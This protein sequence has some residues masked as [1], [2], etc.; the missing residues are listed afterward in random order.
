MFF[1]VLVI[2]IIF[3]TIF[4][5]VVNI[6][7]PSFKNSPIRNKPHNPAERYEFMSNNFNEYV[8]NIDP[9]YINTELPTN[10]SIK[11]HDGKYFLVLDE[12]NFY[13]NRSL[14]FI[15]RK[16]NDE[17]IS[18]LYKTIPYLIDFSP[19]IRDIKK[20]QSNEYRDKNLVIKKS[21]SG[22]L[23]LTFKYS[24]SLYFVEHPKAEIQRNEDDYSKEYIN[25]RKM[26][27]FMNEN[28]YNNLLKKDLYLSEDEL[29]Y[30]VHLDNVYDGRY[31][32]IFCQHDDYNT[33]ILRFVFRELIPES[34]DILKSTLPYFIGNLSTD[35][36]LDN[37]LLETYRDTNLVIKSSYDGNLVVNFEGSNRD[38]FLKYPYANMQKETIKINDSLAHYT[39]NCSF[40]KNNF[41]SHYF[42]SK[43]YFD[44]IRIQWCNPDCNEYLACY[45]NDDLL[46]LY[47]NSK[48]D[49]EKT[50]TFIFRNVN[51]SS[52][53]LARQITQYLLNVCIDN[54][55]IENLYLDDY[56]NKIFEVNYEYDLDYDIKS[57]NEELPGKVSF[58][59]TYSINE[60]LKNHPVAIS[61]RE[62]ENQEIGLKKYIDRYSFFSENFKLH[63][64]F[65]D[66]YYSL[67]DKD[68]FP[69]IETL[70]NVYDG[71]YFI[72]FHGYYKA[73]TVLRFIFR[74]LN[75]E[76][77]ELI[78]DSIKHL[79]NKTVNYET[80]KNLY[81]IEN[82]DKNFIII[83]DLEKPLDVK[84][85]GSNTEYFSK[86]PYA[87]FQRKEEDA[88]N[89][90]IYDTLS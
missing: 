22:D 46:V 50:L 61:R 71:K 19:N 76:C 28:F 78:Y 44:D 4:I 16:I 26:H 1:L 30:G 39:M 41:S 15:F 7:G 11:V 88:K 33:I 40:L 10:K 86:Y 27:D 49:I 89:Y 83:D 17:C 6:Y 53:N 20:L 12:E 21:S 5:I 74:E 3:A 81:L 59:F 31:F 34:I 48:P 87:L 36:N 8:F 77:L 66:S 79:T 18:I 84:F 58:N 35:I 24:N 13:G 45:D 63:F 2:F 65:I 14:K 47:N 52:I 67:H 90:S 32:I 60:Y 25:F 70:G 54:Y 85:E 37:L 43:L 69:Y 64:F 42:D 55:S 23:E 72:I 56:S 73:S 38:Y 51:S 68:S 57:P 80:I 75:E 62:E 9:Y 82:D 29:L